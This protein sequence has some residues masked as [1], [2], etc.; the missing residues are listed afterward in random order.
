MTWPGAAVG[1]SEGIL[2]RPGLRRTRSWPLWGFPGADGAAAARSEGGWKPEKAERGLIFPRRARGTG[3]DEW[4]AA[5]GLGRSTG[6]SGRAP[7]A[8]RPV[9]IA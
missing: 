4:G 3:R 1:L 6:S 2:P 8:L 7:R 9:A 5:G